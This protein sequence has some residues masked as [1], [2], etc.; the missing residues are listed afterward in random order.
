MGVPV[1]FSAGLTLAWG[2]VTAPLEERCPGWHP[3]RMTAA[4][5]LTHAE[6]DPGISD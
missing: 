3:G 1:Y 2:I 5:P 6:P 4:L